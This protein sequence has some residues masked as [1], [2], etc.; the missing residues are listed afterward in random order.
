[1]GLSSRY[2]PVDAPEF[3]Q[4]EMGG[5]VSESSF[6]PSFFF[7]GCGDDLTYG[8]PFGEIH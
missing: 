4:D 7:P 3:I 8:N 1:M 5:G 2:D 6:G